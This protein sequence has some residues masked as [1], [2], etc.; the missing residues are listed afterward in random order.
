MAKGYW[1]VRVDITD[2]EQYK[3]Y[4]AANAAPLARWRP[5]TGAHRNV[6]RSRRHEPAPATPSSNSEATDGAR[7]LEISGPEAILS[8]QPCRPADLVI[9]EGMKG[10]SHSPIVW[11]MAGSEPIHAEGGCDCRTCVTG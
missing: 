2:M 4:V 8:R 1:I 10:R 3:K 7:L 9:I 6:R 5:L 11:T